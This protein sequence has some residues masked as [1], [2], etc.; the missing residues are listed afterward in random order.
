MS[1]KA[2]YRFQLNCGRMGDLSG[3]FVADKERIESAMGERVYYG[4]VLGKHSEIVEELD[5][6]HL[7]L[8]SD[9]PEDVE[10][11]ERLKLATGHNPLDYLDEYG[12]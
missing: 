11:F 4:E 8:I 6:S 3:I 1:M 2:I 7:T 5:S 10:V 12:R 9:K